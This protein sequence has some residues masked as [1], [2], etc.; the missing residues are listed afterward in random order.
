MTKIDFDN[1]ALFSIIIMSIPAFMLGPIYILK[2]A[3]AWYGEKGTG[4][5]MKEFA[6]DFA[7]LQLFFIINIATFSSNFLSTIIHLVFAAF[8][9][10][11][12]WI[13]IGKFSSEVERNNWINGIGFLCCFLNC[14]IAGVNNMETI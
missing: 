10:V 3:R 14:V 8:F 7:P 2:V 4:K 5:L 12:R 13:E 11:T 1:N 6:L 9:L